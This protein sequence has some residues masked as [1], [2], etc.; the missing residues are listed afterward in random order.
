MSAV[1]GFARSRF[2]AAGWRWRMRREASRLGVRGLAG[3]ALIVVAIAVAAST[4]WPAHRRAEAARAETADLRA[5][6][7][8]AGPLPAAGSPEAIARDATPLDTFHAWFPPADT[9]PE[10]IGRLHTAAR[11]NGLSL[12][13]STDRLQVTRGAR[14][15][16]YEITLPV[17][18]T[19]PQL[20]GF[21]A[22]ALAK[23]PAAAL[24][25]SQFKRDSVAAPGL[26]AQL[27][28][29]L[30]LDLGAAP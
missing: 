29:A 7:H 12:D 28:F 16:R 20:R 14:L 26:E 22:E 3:L 19:Y 4:W 18:G 25:E 10:W 30:Y 24:E 9:L 8:A 11:R 2:D 17:R 5:R 1:T 27:R 13:T 23:V 15:A 21:V 6:V